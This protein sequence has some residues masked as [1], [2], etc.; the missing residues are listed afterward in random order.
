MHNK[1]PV[2][3]LALPF[4]LLM[5]GT[6]ARADPVWVGSW[7]A[8]PLPPRQ[9]A[10]RFPATPSFDHQTIRQVVRLSA[11]GERV[12]LRLTNEYGG[13]SLR[14]GAARVALA[15][16][17]GKIMPGTEHAVTFGGRPEATVAAGAPL[18][19]DP[20]A[21]EVDD[22]DS[23]S[24]SLYF[25]D[26]TGQCTCHQVGMQTAFVSE[27]GDFVAGSFAVADT[28]QARA[29]LSG[30]EVQTEAPAH[31]IVA[32]GDSIT[33]GVGSTPDANHRWP[34]RL[35]DRLAARDGSDDWAVVNAGISGNQVL[36]DGAGE[37]ALARFDRDV[38]A[39]PGVAAVIV[40]EG[41]NDIGI[42]L[43]GGGFAPAPAGPKLTPEAL[44]EGLRQ[45]IYRAH[46]KG[47]TIYGATI[48]PFEGAAY[49]SEEGEAVR[50]A[51]NEWIRTGN[52]FDAVL[53]FDAVLR[54][55]KHPARI[56]EPLQ[57]GDHLHGSDAGYEA[58]AESIDLSLFP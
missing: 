16:A 21:L 15:D 26:D 49:Y 51:V 58:L 47:L 50:Q 36:H 31:T 13:T 9:A 19:S 22:L 7:A 48:A 55:P 18:L 20:V 17:D 52:E 8:S 27:P 57:A 39:V 42:G 3:V 12:R 46:S 14:V 32:F 11:G 45:L 56:A 53:D 4:L 23:L 43:G 35:A 30:V 24:I 44:I 10:G 37:S 41:I 29:F 2:S 1:K 33:D 5:V 6:V 28:L 40:F 54:D 25:P 38:L 34:D